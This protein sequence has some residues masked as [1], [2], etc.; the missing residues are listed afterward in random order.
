[1]PGMQDENAYWVGAGVVLALDVALLALLARRLPGSE[2]VARRRVIVAT[3]FLVWFMLHA[4]V[5]WGDAWGE[6]YALVLP[7]A[8]RLVLPL[9]LTVAYT[10][11][12][13]L[14]L[15]WVPRLPGPGVVWFC[16]LGAAVQS[17][18]G[19]WE[20]FGLGMLH[21]VPSLRTVGA[22]ALFAYGFAESVLLWCAVLAL[23]PLVQRLAQA[24]L[25]RLR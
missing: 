12:T 5:F 13:K 25:E 6:T 10:V 18:E 4:A 14:L 3:S 11:V 23:F 21:R 2:L 16:G 20:L 22:P 1:M 7:P 9:F 17:L 19:V 15:D 24:L 8:A